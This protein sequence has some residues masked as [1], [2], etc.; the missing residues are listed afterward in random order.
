V[1]CVPGLKNNFLPILAMEDMVFFVTFHRWK[2]LIQPY[3]HIP[4]TTMVIGV[5]EGTLHRL[6]GKHV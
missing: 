3:K 5:R 4:D 2:V 1:L 6:W